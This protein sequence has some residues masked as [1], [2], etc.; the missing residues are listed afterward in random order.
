MEPKDNREYLE[1]EY[2]EK[3]FLSEGTYEWL[4]DYRALKRE[5]DMV[6]A[7]ESCVLNIGCGNSDLAV[8]MHRDGYKRVTSIDLSLNVIEKMKAKHTDDGLSWTQMNM[9]EM[10]FTDCVFD[11]AIDKATMDVLQTDNQDPWNPCQ[12]A[13]ERVDRFYSEVGRVLKPGG[14][15]L[16]VSFEQPHFRKKLIPDGFDWRYRT[17]DSGSFPYFLYILVKAK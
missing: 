6:L 14:I 3:R 15:L 11:A 1:P 12:E 10:E 7:K 17:V 5:F 2:W 8:E 9:L 13:V 16:Q 4:A